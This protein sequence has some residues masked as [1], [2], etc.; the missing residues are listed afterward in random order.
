MSVRAI[1]RFGAGAAVL[2]L[3]TASACGG[4]KSD[5][6]SSGST[7]TTAKS[8]T[9]T[10]ATTTTTVA[11]GGAAGSTTT[12]KAAAAADPRT[13]AQ[14]AADTAI[15]KR[16][17]L[18][19]G[20]LPA[21]WAVSSDDS[22]S[23]DDAPDPAVDQVGKCLGVDADF[24]NGDSPVDESSD[25][26]DKEDATVSSEISVVPS[27]D[28]AKHEFGIIA[29]PKF[30]GCYET[31]AEAEFTAGAADPSN[32]AA[33]MKVG[34]VTVSKFDFPALGD[35]SLALRVVVPF[36]YQGQSFDMTLDS[37]FIRSGR[38]E[39]TLNASNINGPTDQAVSQ[40]AA[41]AVMARLT[42]T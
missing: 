25:E 32:G 26:F 19:A 1:R 2:L 5:K 34:K 39:V 10:T 23:S 40:A 9:T 14:L 8:T 38:S 41:R 28:V 11:K 7:S 29:G 37:V 36:T 33:G 30:A 15:A 12:T 31:F 35:Q 27:A 16:A 42:T 3:L 20:D 4:G 24:L 13:K 21:G 6:V 18:V 22:D 17:N